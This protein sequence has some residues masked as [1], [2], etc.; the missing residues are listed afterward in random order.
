MPSIS[1]Y[2]GLLIVSFPET[3]EIEKIACDFWSDLEPVAFKFKNINKWIII[4]VEQDGPEVWPAW[5]IKDKLPEN[6]EIYEKTLPPPIDSW[7]A[8]EIFGCGG[9]ILD[10][11]EIIQN[12]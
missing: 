5:E 10:L 3:W 12:R 11:E 2:K 4:W 8:C 6:F 7:D 9:R 1:M